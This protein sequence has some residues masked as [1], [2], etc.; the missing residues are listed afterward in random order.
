M[1][2]RGMGKVFTE[3]YGTAHAVGNGLQLPMVNRK[4]V[5]RIGNYYLYA[6]TG[7]IDN[8]KNNQANLLAVII[9]NADMQKVTIKDGKLVT[10]EGNPLKYYVIYIAQDKTLNGSRSR[11]LKQKYQK[12]VVR[13]VMHSRR[14]K[15]FFS[16][17]N[18]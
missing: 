3:P 4:K 16:N 10:P 7:T 1:Q 6:K 9:T 11:I 8:N 14:F 12:D 13:T 17:N 18:N 2:M 15:D 5:N